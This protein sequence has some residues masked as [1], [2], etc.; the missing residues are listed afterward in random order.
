MRSS[1]GLVTIVVMSLFTVVQQLFNTIHCI[2]LLILYV[3]V[4]DMILKLYG[5]NG[6]FNAVF[7]MILLA[8]VLAETRKQENLKF[9]LISSVLNS[10]E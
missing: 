1:S 8:T 10:I 9:F 3:M 6:V 5:R 7:Q 2:N 4:Y